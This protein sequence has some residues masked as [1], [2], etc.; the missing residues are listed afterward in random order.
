MKKKPF[1]LVVLFCVFAF[2]QSANTVFMAFTGDLMVHDKQI[3]YAYNAKKDN[4][5]FAHSFQHVLPYLS[6]PDYTVG[7][8]EVTLAGKAM[9]YT[10]YPNFN[11]PDEF[12]IAIKNAGFDLLTTANN[13]SY[14]KLEIGFL[15][16]IDMLD[17]LGIDHVGT[18]KTQEER[19]SIFI[20]EING[21]TFAFLSYTYGTNEIKPAKSYHVNMLDTALIAQDI[22]KA[23]SLN[24]DFIIILPHMGDEYELAPN[25]SHKE[26]IMSMFNAGADIVI[27]SHP[28]VLQPMEFLNITLPNG[29]TKECFV[30]YSMGNFVSSQRTVPRDAGIILNIIFEKKEGKKAAIKKVSYIPTW[31]KFLDTA[32]KLDIRVFSVYDA[33]KTYESNNPYKFRLQD[34]ERLKDVHKD[35]AKM[36]QEKEIPLENIKN[37][38]EFERI[39]K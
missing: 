14:D 37:E 6:K 15:R 18:Y 26:I 34:R 31:V 9:V 32:G 2:A 3:D 29:E 20:K 24:P 39:K 19:D 1:L 7:N 8:L 21:I 13:H 22:R 28:H 11:A 17:S 33:L 25:D 4:Y 23:K 38:Y 5:D 35:A 12:G 36:F 10:G 16:T 27:S 30:A